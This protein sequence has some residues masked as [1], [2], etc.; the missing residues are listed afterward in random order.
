MLKSDL[1]KEIILVLMHNPS[2][3]F[4]KIWGKR[5]RSNKFAYHLKQLVK[6][7]LVKK[8]KTG[9][10]QLTLNGK[11]QAL[12]LE[13]GTGERVDSPLLAVAVLIKKGKKYLMLE[14]T[15][16]PFF[17]YWGFHGGKLRSQNYVFDQARES[18]KNETGLMCGLELKG[19][20]SSKTYLDKDLLYNHHLIVVNATQPKGKL[21]S[22]T[23]KGSNKWVAEAEIKNQK[24]LPN[25][26]HLVKISKSPGFTWIEAD[27][28]QENDKMKI[29]VKRE[30]SF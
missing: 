7:G 24:I 4:N 2:L 6:K 27:R 22:K 1:Q 26:P 30:V 28:I 21:I 3:T 17:G 25:I 12:F 16:E 11:R 23:K 20:F 9:H 29:K 15:K 19:V 5:I 18:V 14:R 13:A 10:Y 8:T